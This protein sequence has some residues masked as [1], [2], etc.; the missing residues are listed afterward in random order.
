[1][2]QPVQN[3]IR[4]GRVLHGGVPGI[5]S[6]LTGDDGS[7]SIIPFLDDFEELFLFLPRDR[8]DQQVVKHK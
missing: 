6:E 4:K 1:M 5:Y 2:Y 7:F 8:R 3:S